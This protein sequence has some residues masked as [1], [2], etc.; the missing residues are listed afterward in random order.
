MLINR[1]ILCVISVVLYDFDLLAGNNSP[2]RWFFYEMCNKY[3][4]FFNAH[5]YIK[6]F[7]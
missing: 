6:D 4:C 3:W 2:T 1:F 5:R 7:F